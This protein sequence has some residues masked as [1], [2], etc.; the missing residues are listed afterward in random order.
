MCCVERAW[1]VGGLNDME[2]HREKDLDQ[3]FGLAVQ[4]NLHEKGLQ[5][6][7]TRDSQ[8]SKMTVWLIKLKQEIRKEL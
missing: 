6:T 4:Y 7:L 8:I 3:C 1:L 2:E 5:A